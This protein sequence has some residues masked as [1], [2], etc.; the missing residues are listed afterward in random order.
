MVKLLFIISVL[1]LLMHTLPAAGIHTPRQ[2]RI[3]ET[4]YNRT[5]L[6]AR[7]DTKVLSALSK[8]KN[9][10]IAKILSKVL[11][12]DPNYGLLHAADNKD[13]DSAKFF[14]EIGASS[15]RSLLIAANEDD[16]D[17]A[18]FLEELGSD[19]PTVGF[20]IIM[21]IL[22]CKADVCK[23]IMTHF[24]IDRRELLLHIVKEI[25][26]NE[27]YFEFVKDNALFLLSIDDDSYVTLQVA[28]HK[29]AKNKQ[30]EQAQL[31]VELGAEPENVLLMSIYAGEPQIAAFLVDELNTNPTS[32]LVKA[33]KEGYREPISTA[34]SL[35]GADAQHEDVLAAKNAGYSTTPSDS[36][37][38]AA[39]ANFIR[40]AV[41]AKTRNI[42]RR[43]GLLL[44]E[45]ILPLQ[46]A[47]I[48]RLD[49]H[50]SKEEIY[51]T[52]AKY[53]SHARDAEQQEEMKQQAI[54]ALNADPEQFDQL[55]AFQRL[56]QAVSSLDNLQQDNI[57]MQ[58]ALSNYRQFLI[59]H[60]AL[61]DEETYQELENFLQ[62]LP[63]D[64]EQV[65]ASLRKEMRHLN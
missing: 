29:V 50:F 25:V 2:Q 23:F 4:W 35:L 46:E 19:E 11:F 61:F 17:N 38:Q 16:L 32:A 20:A 10:R 51:E 63:Q 53:L 60:K 33:I 37:S 57:T 36:D 44:I 12:L 49:S 5:G 18:K 41:Q 48:T 45:K 1:A 43:F 40:G 21:A 14:I 62:Q 27:S 7:F 24:D 30:K 52:L 59:E 58:E 55:V 22:D 47:V 39:T 64:E 26:S 31:L 54:A 3:I 8:T 9:P 56:R 6:F 15:A 34:L 42:M 13:V 28:L 65:A